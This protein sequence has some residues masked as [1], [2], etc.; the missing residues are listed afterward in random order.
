MVLKRF[1]IITSD[2]IDSNFYNNLILNLQ[3]SFLHKLNLVGKPDGTE[4]L[5]EN[6]VEMS[7]VSEKNSKV[8]K[9]QAN[10]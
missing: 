10:Y 5:M 8:S 6:A 4:K 2:C 7:D 1:L 3:E 9:N